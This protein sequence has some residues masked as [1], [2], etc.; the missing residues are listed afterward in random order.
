MR[1][2]SSGRPPAANKKMMDKHEIFITNQQRK[3]AVGDDLKEVIR[4]CVLE[5]LRQEEF[6]RTAEVSVTL[7]SNQKIR[8]YNKEFRQKDTPTDVLSFPIMEFDENYHTIEGVGDIDL[9]LQEGSVLLGDIVLSLEQ[10]KAQA[11][12]FGH[13]FLREVGYLTVHS[14]Y[15]LLGYDHE[16]PLKQAVMRKKEEQVLE[17]LNLP[18]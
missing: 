16:E 6:D 8:Q 13:G 12:E 2:Q 3:L 15:H 18:R 17:K 5:V 9:D 4:S 1:R 7:V 14:M 11:Q 10:A